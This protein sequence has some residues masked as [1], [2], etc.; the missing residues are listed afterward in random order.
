MSDSQRQL[1]HLDLILSSFDENKWAYVRFSTQPLRLD[2]RVNYA[3]CRE[4]QSRRG[5]NLVRGNRSDAF[6]LTSTS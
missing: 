1:E 5:V 6:D 4:S 3:T 2:L